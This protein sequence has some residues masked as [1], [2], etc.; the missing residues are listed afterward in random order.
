M[1]LLGPPIEAP[2]RTS[3]TS[4]LSNIDNKPSDRNTSTSNNQDASASNYID[5]DEEDFNPPN[6]SRA[7]YTGQHLETPIQDSSGSNRQY[8][9]D[10]PNFKSNNS[11]YK[12]KD[13]YLAL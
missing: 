2:L 4:S 8:D 5:Y 11:G 3:N 13:R 1:S 7:N 9:L 10:S 12:Y 6:L